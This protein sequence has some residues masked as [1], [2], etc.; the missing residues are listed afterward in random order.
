[1][2]ALEAFYGRDLLVGRGGNCR[3]TIANGFAVEEDGAG[4]ALA[5]AA[6]VFCGGEVQLLGGG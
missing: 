4:T 3:L 1:M 6:A 5:F 2:S